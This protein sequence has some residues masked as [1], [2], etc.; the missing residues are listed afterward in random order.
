MNLDNSSY[1]LHFAYVAMILHFMK[2]KYTT[3][4]FIWRIYFSACTNQRFIE[5]GVQLPLKIGAVSR[6]SICRDDCISSCLYK[7]FS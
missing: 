5:L 6:K 2:A 3:T 7:W 4:D 1:L